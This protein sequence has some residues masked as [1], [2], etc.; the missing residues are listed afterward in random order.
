[1]QLI[2]KN[3]EKENKRPKKDTANRTKWARFYTPPTPPPH[4]HAMEAKT[5]LVGCTN[6]LYII[7]F[8]ISINM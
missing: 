6:I 3:Q 7:T 5:K 8:L 4:T 2:P 1:M